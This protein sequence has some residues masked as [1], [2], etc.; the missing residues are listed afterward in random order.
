MREYVQ[1]I[2]ENTIENR[3]FHR[4]GR[5]GSAVD[6]RRNDIT[7]SH[8]LLHMYLMSA[9]FIFFHFNSR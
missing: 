8:E 1:N 2:E 5:M 7:I 4:M 3:H 9:I 6:R